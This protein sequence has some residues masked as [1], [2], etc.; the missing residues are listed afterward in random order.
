[1]RNGILEPGDDFGYGRHSLFRQKAVHLV[2]QPHLNSG[3]PEPA[4]P[5]VDFAIVYF[6]KFNGET[7]NHLLSPD[8]P[9]FCQPVMDPVSQLAAARPCGN[10]VNRTALETDGRHRWIMRVKRG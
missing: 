1:M 5:H 8:R 7:H 9:S 10:P 4:N 2:A 6:L 3:I